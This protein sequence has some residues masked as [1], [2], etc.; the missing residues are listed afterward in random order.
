[1]EAP[2]SPLSSRLSRRAVGAWRDLQF[3]QSVPNE[4]RIQLAAS[5]QPKGAPGLAF[6]TWD[7]CNQFHMEAPLSPLSSRLSRPAVG[8]QPRDLQ[9]FSPVTMLHRSDELSSRPERSVGKGPAVL[10][11]ASS[12]PHGITP[13]PLSSRLSRLPWDRSAG[14]CSFT[15][16]PLRTCSHV[17]VI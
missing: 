6:E 14:I 13:F 11:S 15:S 1:M 17:Q 16:A 4:R 12:D 8:A 7:P 5:E 9:F 10:P 2:L 3:S